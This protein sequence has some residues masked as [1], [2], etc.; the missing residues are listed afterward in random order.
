MD[1]PKKR[2]TGEELREQFEQ[3]KEQLT[4]AECEE[5]NRHIEQNGRV[6]AK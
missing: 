2:L 3:R 5:I 4:D 1:L 6:K